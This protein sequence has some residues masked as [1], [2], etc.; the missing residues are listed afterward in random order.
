MA[1]RIRSWRVWGPGMLLMLGLTTLASAQFGGMGGSMKPGPPPLLEY[2][3]QEVQANALV[4]TLNAMGKQRWDIFQVVPVWK[5][6]DQGGGAEMTPIRYQ[7][8][9]RRP[10]VEE[11]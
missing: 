5:F 4:E 2:T 8:F 7:I 9:G 1:M 6:Q 10:K 11:K 3:Q